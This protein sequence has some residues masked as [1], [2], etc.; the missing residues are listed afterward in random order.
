MNWFTEVC[1]KR[2]ASRDTK[3]L[4]HKKSKLSFA[5]QHLELEWEKFEFQKQMAREQLEQEKRK[6]DRQYFVER[7]RAENE[8]IQI[9]VNA[10]FTA[11]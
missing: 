10:L 8:R 5:R 11:H 1:D 2:A 9:A 6:S 3:L 4:K 7:E